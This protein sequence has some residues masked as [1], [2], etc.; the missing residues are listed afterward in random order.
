MEQTISVKEL[1][2]DLPKIIKRLERGERFTLIYHSK[3]VGELVPRRELK[4]LPKG[5]LDFWA[6]PPKKFM[7]SS[8]KS[9]VELV[10]EDRDE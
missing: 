8:K 2:L 4:V 5:A 6:N 1:R 3:P 9:A 7:F 10:R